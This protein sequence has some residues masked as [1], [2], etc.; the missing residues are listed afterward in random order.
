MTA[1]EIAES[2]LILLG[3]VGSTAHGL[4][5]PGSDDHDEMGVCMEPPT[6]VVGLDHFEQDVFRT[7]PQGVRSEHGD[8]DRTIYSARKFCRLAMSGNPTILLLLFIESE[9]TLLLGRQLQDLAPAFASRKAGKAF[10]GYATQQRQRLLGERGQMNV[11]RPDLVNAHG[12]DTK[13]AMHM[14][15]LGYQGIEYLETGKIT[16]PMPEETRA[17]VYAVRSGEVELNDVLT[18]AGENERRLEDL[19]TES[20]LPEEPDRASVNYWLIYAYRRHWEDNGLL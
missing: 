17:F 10:L 16:L 5:V 6:H 12:Y 13:Y 11:K 4:N 20:P 3:T 15:R 7:K 8:T 1:R 2:N 18:E 9:Y 14:L 19:L